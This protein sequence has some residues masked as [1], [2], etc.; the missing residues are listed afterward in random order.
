LRIPDEMVQFLLKLLLKQI[1]CCEP[2][3]PLILTA[4]FR[5][6]YVKESEILERSESDILPPTRQ[7]CITKLNNNITKLNKNP[8]WL[9]KTR[10]RLQISIVYQGKV[11]FD[12]HTK[13]AMAKWQGNWWK[14]ISLNSPSGLWSM[15]RRESRNVTNLHCNVF[16]LLC[17]KVSRTSTQKGAQNF[18]YCQQNTDQLLSMTMLRA[19]SDLM[20]T[21]G[22]SQCSIL[23][24]VS[25]LSYLLSWELWKLN[26]YVFT[27]GVFVNLTVVQIPVLKCFWF[28]AF[29]ARQYFMFTSTSKSWNVSN[30]T[31]LLRVMLWARNMAELHVYY[32]LTWLYLRNSFP[33]QNKF[34]LPISIFEAPRIH[35][36]K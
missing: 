21:F 29:Y 16:R 26:V 10:H 3:F 14:G 17:C 31:A 30:F 32:Y 34:K 6:L 35:A 13:K 1:S 9:S 22:K 25:N 15:L 18:N 28:A 2:R 23:L 8:G 7:P 4:K 20:I 12:Q 19:L 36:W 5:F 24:F 33:N 27:T 11:M